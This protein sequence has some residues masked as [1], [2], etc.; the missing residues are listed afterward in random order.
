LDAE[1]A[2]LIYQQMKKPETCGRFCEVSSAAFFLI[3][4][5]YDTGV[6][7]AKPWQTQLQT[8]HKNGFAKG[9]YTPMKDKK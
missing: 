2:C 1:A 3:S 5:L 8:L 7:L 9:P 4:G 6:M